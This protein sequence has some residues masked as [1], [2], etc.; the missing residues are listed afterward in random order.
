MDVE[1]L[2]SIIIGDDQEEK[3]NVKATALSEYINTPVKHT[4]THLV[5][6]YGKQTIEIYSEVNDE[7]FGFLGM[8][9]LVNNLDNKDLGVRY[10]L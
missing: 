10:N 3:M 6:E 1:S 2:G 5:N 8:V 4:L 9:N 7:E